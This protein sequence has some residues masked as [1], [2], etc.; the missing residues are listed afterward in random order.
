MYVY[1]CICM[2]M[3]MYMYMHSL[4]VSLLHVHLENTSIACNFA[5]NGLPKLGSR[6]VS[7]SMASENE[8]H[9][10]AKFSQGIF[11]TITDLELRSDACLM[12]TRST[13]C[14]MG[15]G[16]E[17]DIHGF[18]KDTLVDAIFAAGLMDHVQC[19]NELS[20]FELRADI[21][22]VTSKMVP[23]GVVEV[24]KPDEGIMASERVHG[25]I[26]D[27]M[28]RLQSFFGLKNVF[29]I[30]STYEQWRIYW[31]PSAGEAA[32]ST[33][34]L[35]DACVEEKEEGDG[36][37]N[38]EG[39]EG[40]S[41]AEIKALDDDTRQLFGTEVYQWD[42]SSLPLVLCSVIIKMFDSPRGH[43]QDD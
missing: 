8:K 35:V 6:G 26:Y 28:L 20:V 36:Q 40:D 16:T 10:P 9:L 30:V 25:Q 15:W 31:L 33:N 12:W 22:V 18:V 32:A 27:Y 2:Y 38:D 41:D 29:G 24:K 1:V 34:K 23:I 17:S 14:K 7:K 39:S 13:Q 3:Y 42:N 5:V 4:S 19:F 11:S 21:W 43:C 37:E